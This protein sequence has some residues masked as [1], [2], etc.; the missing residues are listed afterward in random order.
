[1][2][3]PD[4]LLARAATPHLLEALTRSRAVGIIGPRQV[5]KTTLVRDLIRTDFPATYV[6]LDDPATRDAALEDPTGF[7]AE[8]E[9]PTIIDEIQR[10]PDLM[11]AIKVRMDR[12]R[13]PGQFLITG[14]ANIV[15]LPTIRDALPGRVEYVHLWPLSQAE[16]AG[17]TGNLVDALFQGPMSIGEAEAVDR[18]SV[19][20][21][22]AA[23]GYPRVHLLA[24]GARRSFFEAYVDTVVGREVPDVAHLR[25]T[26]AVGRLLRLVAGRSASLLSRRSLAG[27]LGVGDKT[28]DHHLRILGD[29]MLVRFH[30]AWLTSLSQREIKTPK[31]YLTDTGMLSALVGADAERVSKDQNLTGAVFETFVVMELVKLAGWAEARPRLYHY[32]DRDGYEVDLVMERADGDI[33]GVEVKSGA[34]VRPRDFR[35]LWRLRE[36]SGSR[37][38]KGVVLHGGVMRL[39]FGDRLYAVPMSALW[40]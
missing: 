36:R 26:A 13:R 11:L 18:A 16:I 28:V 17:R 39:P 14:S 19:T 23:G 22:V 10:V 34:T 3:K 5:G 30:P 35:G 12:D 25:D 15:T 32:R 9:G 20:R 2:T 40:S 37:F 6:T 24:P 31:V 4:Q 7:V 38:H 29:L 8:M 27:D 1:M 33:V 21:R